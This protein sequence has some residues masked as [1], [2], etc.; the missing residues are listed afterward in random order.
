MSNIMRMGGLA[1]GVDTETMIKKLMD[2]EKVKYNKLEQKKQLKVWSR[3]AYNSINKKIATFISDT[4]KEFGI[5]T[6]SLGKILPSSINSLSW[7]K[8][9][10]SGNENIL[11]VKATASAPYGTHNVEVVELAEGVNFASSTE[12]DA[13]KTLKELTSKLTGDDDTYTLTINGQGVELKGSDSVSDLVYK[14]N[15]SVTGVKAS[16]DSTAKRFFINTSNTGEESVISV[17]DKE[18]FQGLNIEITAGNYKDTLSSS[19]TI[20]NNTLENLFKSNDKEYDWSN[21]NNEYKMKIN[22][23]ELTFSKSDKMEDIV[24]K[25]NDTIPGIEAKYDAISKNFYLKDTSGSSDIDVA[26]S[27]DSINLFG[28]VLY[29]NNNNKEYSSRNGK[30]AE[31]NF[32]GANGIKYA[33]NQF[34]INGITMDVKT[35]GTTTVKV[36]TDVDAVYDKIKS[37]I[38]KYN[39]LIGG[40]DEKLS[41]KKYRDYQPLTEEQKEAM[42]KDTIEKWEQKAKSGILKSDETLSKILNNVRTSLYK[43][44]YKEYEDETNNTEEGGYNALYEIGIGTGSYKNKGKLEI[45]KDST[46]KDLLRDALEKDIDSVLNVLFKSGS[47]ESED[48]IVQRMY[49]NMVDGLEETIKKSGKGDDSSLFT[50]IKINI[51]SSLT[52]NGS[53][54]DID[55]DILD[56]EKRITVENNRLSKK[57]NY[58]WKK[59]TA[60]ETAMNKMNSQSSWLATQLGMAQ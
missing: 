38:E 55:K 40:I 21:N 34:T 25:I 51:F 6:T 24:K 22:N 27:D 54:S 3:E 10:V 17:S 39:E 60:L 9:P 12:V 47:N 36:D 2:A 50:S 4:K 1:S 8:K 42:D 52:S 32:D 35:K 45:L 31:I 53:I 26:I 18:L 57:E 33:T 14:I 28:D 49:D 29:I 37:F 59:F 46:G 5:Q 44:I 43:P 48:G 56:I 15:S 20:D 16:Y 58:Y 7:V 41:E 13:S 19:K 30:D 23:I 11:Q